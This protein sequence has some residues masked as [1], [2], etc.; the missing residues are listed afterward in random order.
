VALKES[1]SPKYPLFNK[2]LVDTLTNLFCAGLFILTAIKLIF[3]TTSTPMLGY[4]NNFDFIRQSSC[5][6]LW[7]YVDGK[8]SRSA[9][10]WTPNAIYDGK[11]EPSQCQKSIDSTMVSGLLKFHQ[12]GGFGTPSRHWA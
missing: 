9:S 2:N 1:I 5:L 6:G 3:I 10:P 12:G 11:I 7:V 4:A 8:Q